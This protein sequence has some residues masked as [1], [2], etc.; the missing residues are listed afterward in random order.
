M[1]ARLSRRVEGWREGVY[2]VEFGSR[3]E[4]TGDQLDG[5]NEIGRMEMG[6][7]LQ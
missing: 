4:E 1:V 6:E 2:L 3:Q 7:V 5:N